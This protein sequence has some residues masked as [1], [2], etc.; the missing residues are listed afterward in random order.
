[1]RL[2]FKIKRML[3]PAILKKVHIYIFLYSLKVKMAKRQ[4]EMDFRLTETNN[5]KK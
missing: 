5:M 3:T 2:I 4:N 1:V